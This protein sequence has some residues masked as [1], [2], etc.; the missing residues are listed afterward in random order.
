MEQESKPSRAADPAALVLGYL[1]F[2]SGSFDPAAWRA[3]SDLYAAAEPAG[4]QGVVERPDAVVSVAAF[5]KERLA[6]LEATEPAFRDSSQ[7]RSVLAV[8]FDRFLSAYRV[9]HADLLEH[10]PP[11]AIERPFFVMA[12]AQAV[13]ATGGPWDDTDTTAEIIRQ[14]IA[15]LNDY[16]GWRPVAVLENG[17]L[18]EPYP[19]ERV[20][21]IPLF[22]A[23]AGTAQGK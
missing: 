3:L 9:F 20:R 18:S 22:V 6:A 17:R 5:L 23:G 8:V 14:A 4:P 21:P 1:N 2:S 10:Q 13:L 19:H 11:G 15:Q 7:A 12:A 16:V